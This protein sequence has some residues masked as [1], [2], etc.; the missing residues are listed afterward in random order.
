[1]IVTQA[2]KLNLKIR[3]VEIFHYTYWYTVLI[4][5]KTAFVREGDERQQRLYLYVLNLREFL[6]CIV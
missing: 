2:K 1:M 6:Y 4:N 5:T 3:K